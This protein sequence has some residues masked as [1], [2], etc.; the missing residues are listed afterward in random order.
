[1]I[2]VDAANPKFYGYSD[3]PHRTRLTEFCPRY[4]NEQT[5]LLIYT[6]EGHTHETTIK[7]I[8]ADDKNLLKLFESIPKLARTGSA[9]ETESGVLI[10]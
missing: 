2:V 8:I 4:N 9:W 6:L 5:N 7:L 3:P 10:G 1:M